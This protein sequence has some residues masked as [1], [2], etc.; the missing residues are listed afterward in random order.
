[1]L[2]MMIVTII[3]S[4]RCRRSRA[5]LAAAAAENS[6]ARRLLD[7]LKLRCGLGKSL[8]QRRRRRGGGGGR[9]DDGGGGRRGGREGGSD[10]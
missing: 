6:D 4:G 10:E 1:M 9:S 7:G 8:G 5:V 2:W 3:I